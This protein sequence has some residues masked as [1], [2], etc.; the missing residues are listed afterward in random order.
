V[1]NRSH[2]GVALTEYPN[3]TA[4]W[5]WISNLLGEPDARLWANQRCPSWRC[6]RDG[7]CLA[8]REALENTSAGRPVEL[9]PALM[10]EQEILRMLS[11]REAA[12]NAAR[13]GSSTGTSTTSTT[14][15][16]TSGTSSGGL[17][18]SQGLGQAL[19]GQRDGLGTGHANGGRQDGSGAPTIVEP[20]APTTPVMPPVPAEQTQW[21]GIEV[22]VDYQQTGAGGR[23]CTLTDHYEGQSTPSGLPGLRNAAI[24]Q[25]RGWIIGAMDRRITNTTDRIYAGP[26][27]TKP[28][29]T[30]K[31]GSKCE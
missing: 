5:V 12:R 6:D 29:Y 14:G 1:C 20:T 19:Q 13:G 31:T 15:T 25:A 10:T 11:E 22:K 26:Q 7:R 17:F 21:Y 27:A 3:A 2:G 9:P 24:S 8:G 30:G 28:A 18:T 16:T 23:K 4:E